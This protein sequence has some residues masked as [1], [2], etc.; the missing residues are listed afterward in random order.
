VGDRGRLD[1]GVE[2]AVSLS[3][4]D[5]PADQQRA[6]RLLACTRAPISPARRRGVHRHR[7]I[8]SG[9]DRRLALRAPAP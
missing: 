4:R 8:W 5:L 7:T 2:V 1:S 6:F 3:Y 9:V